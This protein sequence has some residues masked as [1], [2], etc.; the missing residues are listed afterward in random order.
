MIT[1]SPMRQFWG[2]RRSSGWS[3]DLPSPLA[4]LLWARQHLMID[5]RRDIP[6][7]VAASQIRGQ[8]RAPDGAAGRWVEVWDEGV[9]AA[10]GGEGPRPPGTLVEAFPTVDFPIEALRDWRAAVMPELQRRAIDV[11]REALAGGHSPRDRA[12]LVI[13][14]VQG[15]YAARVGLDTWL[16]S[17]HYLE[18]P[19]ELVDLTSTTDH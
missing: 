4:E 15:P 12:R 5:A 14:P 8:G 10:Q 9:V 11:A 19:R 13:L 18:H 6:P 3:I 1:L 2:D 7:V 17:G 16:D